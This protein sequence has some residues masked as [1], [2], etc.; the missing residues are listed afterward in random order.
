MRQTRINRYSLWALALML[1]ATTYASP[2]DTL[3]TNTDGVTVFPDTR[4]AGGATA[5]RI[6]IIRDNIVR[7]S[8]SPNSTFKDPKSFM[9]SYKHESVKWTLK[10]ESDEV[11]LNTPS[12]AA[13][14]NKVTGAV[15]FTDLS[16]KELLHERT[17]NGRQ[18]TSTIYEGQPSWKLVQ[19]FESQP[20]EGYFGLGQHQDGIYNYNGRQVYFFQ[21]NTEVAV[22]F[23]LSSRNYGILW[24]NYSLTKAGDTREYLPLSRLQLFSKAGEEGWLTT[25][26]APNRDK[27]DS[28]AFTRAESII[29]YS[30]LD[31][32]KKG[33]PAGYPQ[34]TSAITWEGS[35]ASNVPGTHQLKFV[36]GGYIRVWVDGKLMADKWR[37]SWNPGVAILDLNLADHQ[38]H[39]IKIQWLPDGAAS[40]L[41][42]KV[43]PPAPPALQNT[44]SFDS[45]AGQQ[46]DYYFI[47][48]KN[49]DE[50]IGG[51]RVLTG[52]APIVPRWAL[53][54]WQSRERYKSQ[55]EVL[56]TVKTFR[57]RGIPLDNI[58]QDWSYW[59]ENDWGSQEFDATRFPDP[60]GM[61]K[62]L[63]KQ[64]T[65]LMISVWPKVYEGINV[66]NQ[67][68]K[69]GWLYGRNI[70]D[71]QR[72][73]IGEGYISTFYDAFNADARKGF[74]D[75]LNKHL[76]SK[77]LDAWW[78]D[79]SE[80]DILSNVSPEKRIGQMIPSA[81]GL[82]AENL[83]AYPL[84]N[85][86]GIYEGQRGTD[87]N[88]RV[89]LLTRSGYA[90]S[91]R[92]AATIWSGDIGARWEDM[93]TQ[94]T[95]GVN[96]SM[97]GLPYWTMDIG[98]F[99]VEKRFEHPNA[100]DQKEW[101]ELQTRWFQFGTFVP[102][103]RS[104]GQFPFREI[105]N[106]SEPGSP[107]YESMLYY[108]RLRYRLLPYTY[109]LAGM[110]YHQQYT[111]MRGLV[112]DFPNDEH[113][114]TVGHEYMYG[115]SFLI[116]PICEYNRREQSVYLPAGQG[117][118]DLYTGA[119]QEGG[120]E[121]TAKAPYER[122]PV[123]VKEGSII[124]MGPALQY[125]DE[126][127]PYP[128]TL[129]VYTGKDASF[130]IYEDEGTNYNYEKGAYSQIP[131]TY[132]ESTKE[133]SIGDR[134]GTFEGMQLRRQFRIVWISKSTARPLDPEVKPSAQISYTGKKVTIFYQHKN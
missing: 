110:A 4:Y 77:G 85:A 95:A 72:D 17:N 114:L 93:K 129:F 51:Y 52:D 64:H 73:W 68:K 31:D 19:T 82:A 58:V 13:H 90:G 116:N 34:P 119:Y 125:T 97:S 49:A 65:R 42:A 27:P 128:V 94:I 10:N 60:D 122:M 2:K 70:A 32:D 123:Y 112:M 130:T 59:K 61:I 98:G 18:L 38:K 96:F 43:L 84:E 101:Q 41:N 54:F 47:A 88:S 12:L 1:S 75:L 44:F 25:S 3:V 39:P 105:F 117:W 53:G 50:V 111:I 63:H 9:A 109:S 132:N 78:M 131:V 55:Q 28:V 6:Q 16:G 118:F 86:R 15:K 40:Y 69:S 99:G 103:F 102:L 134:K 100:A 24:D 121:V 124:P 37:Q 104:H 115:P 107:A 83:N 8:A 48:G 120:Q 14:I 81:A 5:V 7:V 36:Y 67:F 87:P 33:L 71:R 76:Y 30:Y 35:I 20:Q 133:L 45:D 127:K 46:I 62:E 126:K 23:L 79:A 21:N 80:P 56:E 108:N 66:Y 91:Q 22:P 74:W 29:D 89:F 113:S 106:V 26:Y 11:V 92:Y 57:Q